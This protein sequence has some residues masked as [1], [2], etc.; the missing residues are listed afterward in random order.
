MWYIVLSGILALLVL[1][2]ALKRLVHLPQLW[3]LAT[4]LLAPIVLPVYLARRPLLVDE[5]RRGGSVWNVLKYFTLFWMIF[6]LVATLFGLTLD[7]RHDA[8]MQGIAQVLKTDLA[9]PSAFRVI[10][11]IWLMPIVGATILGLIFRRWSHVEIGPT[12]P[13]A[14]W[15][16]PAI[17]TPETTFAVGIPGK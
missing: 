3:A 10:L 12:G 17:E 13:H 2:D 16:A 6:M 1:V 14:W 8:I 9:S 4:F 7:S 5:V 15:M 11:N